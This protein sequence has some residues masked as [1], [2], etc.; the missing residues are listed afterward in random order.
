MNL[1]SRLNLIVWIAASL[2]LLAVF[3]CGDDDDS[4]DGDSSG[5]DDD[6][7]DDDDSVDDAALGLAVDLAD[8]WI[9]T[10]EPS[11]NAWS[12]DSGVMMMGLMDL[13]EITGDQTYTN[14]A[15]AWID[16]YIETGYS[17][18]SSDTSIPGY[19]ALLLYEKTGESKYLEVGDR[20]WEYISQKAGRTADGG[21][22]HMGWL[23]GNQIWVDT[24]FMV[25]PF[26]MKYGQI[27]QT[28]AP[29][30]EFALQLTV[31]RNHL[32]DPDTGLFRHRYDDDTGEIL[33][34]T[35]L[36]WGRGNGWV[37]AASCM[38]V[39]QL[40]QAIKDNLDFDLDQH[41]SLMLQSIMG[42][43]TVNGR[44]HTILNRN[45][46][47]LETSAA[48]LF[49]FGLG[50]GMGN[51]SIF[52]DSLEPYLAKWIQSGGDQIVLDQ[53]GDT[54]ILG[55][56]YGTSPGDVEYYQQVLKGENVSY[57]LG[58]YL[59]AVTQREKLEYETA[60]VPPSG[61]TDESYMVLPVPCEGLPCAKFFISR[62]NFNQAK[63]VL[64]DGLA[65][66]PDDAELNFYNGLIDG[67]RFATDLLAEID[68][69]YI[70]DIGI[71]E[72]ISWLK[73]EG[74]SASAALGFSMTKVIA[75][76]DFS[77]VLD[78][79]VMIEAGGHSA[80]GRLEYDLGEAYILNALAHLIS[81]AAQ[82]LGYDP[83]LLT[84]LDFGS[85]ENFESSLYFYTNLQKSLD[86][87]DR[88]L[89]SGLLEIA[90]ALDQLVMGIHS[91][92]AETDDQADDL[93]P[94]NLFMLEGTFCIP[95][96]LPETDVMELVESLGIPAFILNNLD[97]PDALISLLNAVKGVIELVAGILPG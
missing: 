70:G 59:L 86:R 80:I 18:T 42:Y 55:T 21:L 4:D 62:G 17:V 85:M 8:T 90:D 46:T 92:M 25:G 14:Y 83:A 91:I 33:P 89:K 74:G 5:D 75:D 64:S 82:L 67:I 37:F 56:S 63:D 88:G 36:Y 24:L 15:K 28:D 76:A 32:Q 39:K 50:L 54:L 30:E 7:N 73:Q 34:S 81:G 57:G 16:H 52:D 31:F 65:S 23:S 3:S 96:V 22:N 40:P 95:G 45:D 48:L 53:A 68:I 10:F 87:S 60:V 9:G 6:D 43:E 2:L 35:P 66:A 1:K 84:E 38:A 20:V 72:L 13:S 19:T 77:T 93:L 51:D 47:Y 71:G 69:I 97:M 41:V 29:Y 61:Q 79:L 44:F 11:Q 12:W 27:T 26:L 58:L 49:A 78:R 94:K